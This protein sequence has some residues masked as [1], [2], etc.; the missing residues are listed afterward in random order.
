[1][2]KSHEQTAQAPH[3]IVC[4]DNDLVTM[5]F[6]NHKVYTHF[7]NIDA[8]LLKLHQTLISM[9]TRHIRH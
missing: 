2:N 6:A 7:D 8:L 4:F 1:M 9:F 3:K 5:Y